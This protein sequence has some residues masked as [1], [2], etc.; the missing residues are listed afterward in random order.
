MPISLS[1]LGEIVFAEMANRKPESALQALELCEISDLD[2]VLSRDRFAFHETKLCPH[3]KYSFDGA[4]RVDVTLRIRPDLAVACELKLGSTRLT[5]SRIDKEL[6]RECHLSH[7]D[8]RISGNMMAILDQR[9]GSIA[10]S[11]GLSV[12]LGDEPVPLARCWFVIVKRQVL[13]RWTGDAKPAFSDRTKCKSINEI[14]EAL[15]G[16][17]EFNELVG[18]LLEF[19]YFDKWL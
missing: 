7:N 8:T 12:E 17:E 11:E 15:G 13:E 5:K 9:F 19:D 2:F 3:G 16:R 6:L 10:P 4:H 18:Q 14:V 1:H